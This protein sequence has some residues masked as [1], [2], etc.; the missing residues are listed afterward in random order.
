MFNQRAE[1]RHDFLA[2]LIYYKVKL[3]FSLPPSFPRSRFSSFSVVT[4]WG[5]ALRDIIETDNLVPKAF[6]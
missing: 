6:P 4:L 2:Q 5:G 3:A 1:N